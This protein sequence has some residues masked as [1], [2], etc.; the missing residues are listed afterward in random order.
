M[1]EIKEI[2]RKNIDLFCQAIHKNECIQKKIN[3]LV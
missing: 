1:C 2:E 3:A